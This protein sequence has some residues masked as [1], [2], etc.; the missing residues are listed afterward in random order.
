[1]NHHRTV[2]TMMPPE[3]ALTKTAAK[4]WGGYRKVTDNLTAK[5]TPKAVSAGC[6]LVQGQG[7]VSSGK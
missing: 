2:G 4:V 5:E 6:Q 3:G 1:M 7:P